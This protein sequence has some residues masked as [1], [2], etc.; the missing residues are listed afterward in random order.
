MEI[1]VKVV[2]Y[3]YRD[4]SFIATFALLLELGWSKM[5]YKLCATICQCPFQPFKQITAVKE[6]ISVACFFLPL[7]GLAYLCVCVFLI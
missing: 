5:S 3:R 2:S 1:G 4:L 6:V 7:L